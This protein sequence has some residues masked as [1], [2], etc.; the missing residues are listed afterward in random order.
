MHHRRTYKWYSGTPV[1]EFG[2]GLHYTNFSAGIPSLPSS[3]SISSLL[4]TNSTAKFKD[5][6]PFT[7]IPVNITNKGSVSSDFVILGFLTGSFG[8]TP[9]PL[10]SLVAYTRLHNI[11]AGSTQTGTLSLTLGSLARADETGDMVLYPGE[12]SLVI[13]TDRKAMWNFTLTGETATLDAWPA[14][15]SAEVGEYVTS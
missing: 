10:K 4:T 6:V 13:D 14:P 2:Y 5:L 9:Y 15:P 1:F 8:P 12:Y 11:T 7:S 3:Y